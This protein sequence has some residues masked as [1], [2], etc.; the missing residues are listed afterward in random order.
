VIFG[1]LSD[2]ALEIGL[3]VPGRLFSNENFEIIL[4]PI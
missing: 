3:P 4:K 1:W 2:D